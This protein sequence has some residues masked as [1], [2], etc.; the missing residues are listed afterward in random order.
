MSVYKPKKK[1][2]GELKRSHKKAAFLRAYAK[3][4][5]KLAAAKSMGI[6]P[7]TV[8]EWEQEDEEFR[9]AV[10]A[11][12]EAD[13][14]ELEKIARK[15]AAKKSDLLMMFLLKGRKPLKYRDNVKVEHAGS[16]TVKDLLLTDEPK[17]KNS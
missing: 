15:R 8:Y 6:G 11:V 10:L 17:G 14:Q 5:G 12:E 2:L 7:R 3:V 16:V 4:G 9:Q 1:D 13:T